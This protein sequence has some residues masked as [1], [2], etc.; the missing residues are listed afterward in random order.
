[1]VFDV[2]WQVLKL[3]LMPL[4][5]AFWLLFHIKFCTIVSVTLVVLYLI[6]LLA[7]EFFFPFIFALHLEPSP[8]MKN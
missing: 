2:L 1:M 4:A 6:S 5:L 8:L 3:S 7:A